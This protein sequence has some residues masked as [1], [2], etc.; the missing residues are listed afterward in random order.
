MHDRPFVPSDALD[1][2]L[3]VETLS[4]IYEGLVTAEQIRRAVDAAWGQLVDVGE[5]DFLPVRVAQRVRQGL[6]VDRALTAIS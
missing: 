2:S 4:R 1:Q 5:R 6:G 3:V